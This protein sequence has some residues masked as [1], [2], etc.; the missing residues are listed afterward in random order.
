[1]KLFKLKDIS[2]NDYN[3]LKDQKTDV[4]CPRCNFTFHG[5]DTHLSIQNHIQHDGNEG[6]KGI[7]IRGNNYFL[8]CHSCESVLPH[9]FRAVYG[10]IG[11]KYYM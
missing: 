1:M 5:Y 4:M 10:G 8:T 11:G 6:F 7:S 9:G 2:P 3:K